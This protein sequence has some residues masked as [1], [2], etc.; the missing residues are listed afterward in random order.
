MSTA[1]EP[2]LVGADATDVETPPPLAVATRPQ[3]VPPAVRRPRT[4]APVPRMEHDV[5]NVDDGGSS[6]PGGTTR[7]AG[8]GAR[9]PCTAPAGAGLGLQNPRRRVRFPGG[10]RPR[11]IDASSGLRVT[12]G[13]RASIPWRCAN[14]RT[15]GHR[16]EDGTRRYERRWRG[17]ESFRWHDTHDTHDTPRRATRRA[18]QRPRARTSG[19]YPLRGGLDSLRCDFSGCPSVPPRP[20]TGRTWMVTGLI[21]STPITPTAPAP[22]ASRRRRLTA[23]HFPSRDPSPVTGPLGDGS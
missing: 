13:R 19:S 2:D 4:P 14:T 5:A 3:P 7:A 9:R 12:L 18:T 6:P 17:F 8:D 23:G 20:A 11:R 22:P 15:T 1:D 16:P 10:V 21:G